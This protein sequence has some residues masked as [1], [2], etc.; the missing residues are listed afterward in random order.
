MFYTN[1]RGDRIRYIGTLPESVNARV[2]KLAAELVRELR[3]AQKA[4]GK[5]LMLAGK[6]EDMSVGIEIRPLVR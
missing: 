2:R 5:R 1:K 3:T 4:T 6:S